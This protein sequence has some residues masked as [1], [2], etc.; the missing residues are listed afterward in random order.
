MGSPGPFRS[1]EPLAAEVREHVDERISG[2]PYER[3]V[4][5]RIV[6]FW[7]IHNR[8]DHEAR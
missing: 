5:Y 1:A 2:L 6:G 8:T 3:H 7:C 4:S